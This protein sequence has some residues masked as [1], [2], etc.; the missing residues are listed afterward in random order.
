MA[1]RKKE[2]RVL[3]AR[4]DTLDFRD[5]MYVPTLMEVPT[6]IDLDDYRKLCVPVLNQGAEGACT[7]FGLATVANYL[8]RKRKVVPE[9]TSVSPRMFYENA[10]RYDEW[11]GEEYEGSSARGAMKGWHKH[12]ICAET[13]WPYN[14]LKQDR[15]LTYERLKNAAKRPLGA[16][17][18][19]N[20]KD[21]VA[22]HTALAEVGILYATALV[23]D[24]WDKIGDNGVI[25]LHDEILGGHAFAI[26][27]F[28]DR[29]FWIQNSWG[30]TW[31]KDGFALIRYDDWLKHGTDVWVARLGAPVILQTPEAVATS[32]S[33]I[34][35]QTKTYAYQDIYPHIISIGNNGLLRES[36]TYGTSEAEV[37]AIFR[38]DF[39]R[40]TRDWS[41]KRILLYAH[42]GLTN[43]QTAIQ[44]VAD[45]RTEMLGA[46]VYP[47]AFIWK[48]DF[49]T[50]LTNL[51]KD[52]VSRRRPEGFLDDAKDF[53]LDRLDDALEPLIRML[54]GNLIWGEMKENAMGAT[55]ASQGGAHIAMKYLAELLSKDASVEVHIA[56][57]SAGAIFHA[58]LIQILTETGKITSGPLQGKKG[59]G[60]RV[61]SCNLWAP[62]CTI[63]LFKQTYLPAI[64]NGGIGRFAL[65]TLTDHAEQDDH[66]ASI[67]HK[68]LLY[69]VSNAFEEKTRIPLFRDGEAILG[70][71]KF[72]RADR[73]IMKHIVKKK[74]EWVLSPNNAR[75]GSP[76]HS[77]A[78]SH[79]D[80]DDDEA[81]LRATL[82]RILQ[83]SEVKVPFPIHRS[84]SSL[85]NKRQ[86]LA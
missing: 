74:F 16:Y 57:H 41:K 75:E 14:P 63:A 35:I 77:T 42:G 33:S 83:K 3:D 54:G 68:S 43:E 8:L 26:V 27:A 9:T 19:V 6:C 56:G 65:F 10:R 46:E 17:F 44:R 50:T 79:G 58:L 39:L 12:G 5:K 49:W 22:M 73:D 62:A 66:C 52:A 31:G 82:A 37:A 48:S 47:L 60:C 64:Q 18:R 59:Y 67:Y 61:S 21:L 72:V 4:P 80:F 15:H 34:A 69:L 28:D 1:K 85:Q 86:R 2:K 78:K 11:V 71:E 36:G 84:A 24:G 29:G 23:H 51:L 38:D 40:I 55:V 30:D 25:P 7:G 70:M 45:Y 53:M 13:L 76:N 20:H 32:Q 81:T